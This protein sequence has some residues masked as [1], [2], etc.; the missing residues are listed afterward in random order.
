MTVSPVRPR[1]VVFC[2]SQI[3]GYMAACWRALSAVPGLDVIVVAE[4]SI[5]QRDHTDFGKELLGGIR[6]ELLTASQM[7]NTHQVAAAV[8]K[9][10]PDVVVISGWFNPAYRVLAANVDRKH[11][12]LVLAIDTPWKGTA[13]QRVARLAMARFF[14]R[15]D[16]IVV[17][18]ERSW[19]LA[20]RLG[21]EERLIHR[22][23]YG[24]DYD[25]F[26]PVHQQRLE[27]ADGWP[28]SFL[29]MG[30]YV[31]DKAIDVLLKGYS[32]YRAS[33]DDVWTLTCCGAGP[34]GSLIR[35]L[36]GVVDR[37]FIQPDDQPAMLVE[38]GVFV[39][40]SRYEP[41]GV[42]IAEAA[43]AGLPIICS[44][45]CGASIDLVRS[46][47]NGLTV[48]TDESRA[49]A[50]AMAWM[51]DRYQELPEMGRRGR[52]L[53]SAYSAQMWARRWTRLFEELADRSP[54]AQQQ[55]M[56]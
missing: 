46:C 18:S 26:A 52:E 30:R 42:V 51:H 24:F 2:W 25:S 10:Q 50:S 7:T 11:T 55:A 34:L 12:Q 3:S 31:H 28:R 32:E 37:G 22:G 33:R 49:L 40:A 39:L 9:L 38:H 53:A 19:Q 45:A 36:E 44:E 14:H 6:C 47:F 43:A 54:R 15:F 17:A 29:F 5:L 8:Q 21:F 4:Q 1:T 41:W 20:R 48:A 13:R 35:G 56:R 27:R 16:A 23:T